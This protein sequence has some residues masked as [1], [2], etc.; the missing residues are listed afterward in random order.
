MRFLQFNVLG[1]SSNRRPPNARP[2]MAIRNKL[3]GSV[4][5]AESGAMPDTN[6]VGEGATESPFNE[7]LAITSAPKGFPESARPEP[8]GLPGDC[9]RRRWRRSSQAPGSSRASDDERALNDVIG[10]EIAAGVDL[11]SAGAVDVADL[12]IRAR[13]ENARRRCCC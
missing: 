10:R 6:D 1:S 2:P 9:P 13:D 4:T 3:D 7:L 11:R 12:L 8:R 5:A